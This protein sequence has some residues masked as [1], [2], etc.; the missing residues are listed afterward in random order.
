V[1]KPV[2]YA[3]F[4]VLATIVAFLADGQTTPDVLI[5]R[6]RSIDVS[7][8]GARAVFEFRDDNQLDTYSAAILDERYRLIGTDTILL[9]RR[10]RLCLTSYWAAIWV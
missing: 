1:D 2:N 9:H 8:A 6:W 5:G 10:W 4:C 3:L 7:P